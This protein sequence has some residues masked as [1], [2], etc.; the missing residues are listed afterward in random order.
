MV[1]LVQ[2]LW[3]AEP[4]ALTMLLSRSGQ[5]LSQNVPAFGLASAA[6]WPS[7]IFRWQQPCLIARLSETSIGSQTLGASAAGPLLRLVCLLA[8]I[9]F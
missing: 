2:L 9:C 6:L 7:T 5:A 1:A 3:F 4:S 8:G